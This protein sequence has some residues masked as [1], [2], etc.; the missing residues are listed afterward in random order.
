MATNITKA[1]NRNG[2]FSFGIKKNSLFPS[3]RMFSNFDVKKL[4][5][6][7]GYYKPLDDIRIRTLSGGMG[8]FNSDW[9]FSLKL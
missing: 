6:F 5:R 7:D 3:L 1:V 8:K 4:K 9:N 2:I